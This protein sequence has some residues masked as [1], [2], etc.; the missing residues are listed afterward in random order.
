MSRP[1]RPQKPVFFCLSFR[2][3][4]TQK[5]HKP[6][7]GKPVANGNGNGAILTPIKTIMVCISI[8]VAVNG[9]SLI[10]NQEHGAEITALRHELSEKTDK[11]YRATDA[12]RDFRL[13]EFR[14]ERNEEKIRRCEA[15]LEKHRDE[16]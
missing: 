16:E 12:E 8:T 1:S 7:G 6:T 5:Q 15:F 13:V 4:D 10:I 2:L 14:F 9:W 11:R 3:A